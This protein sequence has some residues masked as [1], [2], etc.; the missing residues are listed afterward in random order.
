MATKKKAGRSADAVAGAIEARRISSTGQTR[1]SAMDAAS[2]RIK[3]TVSRGTA[4]KIA[5]KTYTSKD[6][7]TGKSSTV[8]V[9]QD[10]SGKKAGEIIKKKGKK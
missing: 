3:R 2:R 10:S 9:W 7:V 5:Y 8:T 1:E 4:G 6:R